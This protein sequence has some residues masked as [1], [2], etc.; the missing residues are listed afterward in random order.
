MSGLGQ[1]LWGG[2]EEGWTEEAF[3]GAGWSGPGAAAA[4]GGPDPCGT[5]DSEAG[6]GLGVGGRLGVV[7]WVDL[8]GWEQ[9]NTYF[10]C[11]IQIQM[12]Q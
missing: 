8:K 1:S 11:N 7:Q 6:M 10:S 2:K 9:K 12:N 4:V 5:L 3:W